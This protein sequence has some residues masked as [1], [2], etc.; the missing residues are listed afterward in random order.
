MLY[1][2]FYA[3][4][5]TMDRSTNLDIYGRAPRGA[6]ALNLDWD[7]HVYV[8]RRGKWV[9]GRRA[10]DGKFVAADEIVAGD[11]ILGGSGDDREPGEVISVD[12]KMAVVAW[13]S[14]VRTAA[15]VSDL[16]RL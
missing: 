3:D 16:I 13:D 5:R 10:A 1:D 7:G 12:G 14:G 8:A 15:P 11:L 6:Y 2:I 9:E 4:R